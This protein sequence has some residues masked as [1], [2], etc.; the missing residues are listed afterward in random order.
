MSSEVSKNKVVIVI[1]IVIIIVNLIVYLIQSK[2][3]NEIDNNAMYTIGY[4]TNYSRAR[5]GG[6]IYYKYFIGGVYLDTTII[7]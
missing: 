1:F 5:H 4:V 3:E 7:S 6:N 2:W